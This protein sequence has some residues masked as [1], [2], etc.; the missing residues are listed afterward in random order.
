MLRILA[1]GIEHFSTDNRKWSWIALVMKTEQ[2]ESRKKCHKWP[3]G[4]QGPPRQTAWSAGKYEWPGAL[5]SRFVF[6]LVERMARVSWTN[7]RTWRG[8]TKKKTWIT[9]RTQRKFGP[10][11]SGI[12]GPKRRFQF[13]QLFSSLSENSD[14]MLMRKW[15]LSVSTPRRKQNSPWIVKAVPLFADRVFTVSHV[16]AA[17]GAAGMIRDC[18]Q[19]V[20]RWPTL[21]KQSNNHTTWH[22]CEAT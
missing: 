2:S 6:W 21:W 10:K 9:V 15:D 4:L 7:H 1:R 22:P 8:N 3:I 17:I 14:L 16:M 20:H 19:G 11:F 12:A 5:G 13:W 18:V